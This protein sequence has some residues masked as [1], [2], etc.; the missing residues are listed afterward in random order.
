MQVQ[1]A[2]TLPSIS[3]SLSAST[4]AEIL[5]I[6]GREREQQSPRALK[7][8]L[9]N[10]KAPQIV[11]EPWNIVVQERDHIFEGDTQEVRVWGRRRLKA[12][13]DA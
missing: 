1:S 6:L 11:V 12:L 2:G 10:G 8:V 13:R 3:F 7:F 4:V 5:M 9:E